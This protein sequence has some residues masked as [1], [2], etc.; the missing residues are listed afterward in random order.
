MEWC[1]SSQ[2]SSERPGSGFASLRFSLIVESS[3]QIN[4][5]VT[6]DEAREHITLCYIVLHCVTP[7]EGWELI[8]ILP[9]GSSPGSCGEQNTSSLSSTSPMSYQAAKFVIEIIRKLVISESITKS[10]SKHDKNWHQLDIKHWFSQS[11]D[12]ARMCFPRAFSGP[13]SDPE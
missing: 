2:Q 10:N 4:C 11:H 7:D 6:P 5:S 3:P 9:P 13:V 12:S 8:S 1:N